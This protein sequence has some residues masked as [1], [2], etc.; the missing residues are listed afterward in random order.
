MRDIYKKKPDAHFKKEHPALYR[1][2]IGVKAGDSLGI[3]TGGERNKNRQPKLP[4]A[5]DKRFHPA[6]LALLVRS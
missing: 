5:V 3:S 2:S 6:L 4:Q 1:K